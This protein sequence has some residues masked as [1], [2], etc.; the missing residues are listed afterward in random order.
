[1]KRP[2]DEIPIRQK[3]GLSFIVA[4][5]ALKSASSAVHYEVM[6]REFDSPWKDALDEF[7][8]SALEMFH[9]A[10]HADVDWSVPYENLD[11][12]LSAIVREAE[13]GK[14]DADRLYRVTLRNGQ[15]LCLLIHAEVQ[16]QHDA[17]LPRR[18]FVYHYR[19]KD[20]YD[21]PLVGLAI[22]GDESSTWRPNEYNY[23]VY[24]TSNSFRFRSVKLLD[25][26]DRFE[27]LLVNPNPIGVVIAAH[28]RSLETYGQPEE[29]SRAKWQ[30]Y[31]SIFQ[32]GWSAERFRKVYRLIDWLLE[33]PEAVQRQLR[34]EIHQ[35]E[36]EHKMP[37]VP[38]YERFAKEEGRVEGREEGREATL[39]SIELALRAKFGADGKRF[40]E[41]LRSKQ[42]TM[43]MLDRLIDTIDTATSVDELRL[44][45]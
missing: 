29:R 8:E 36:Q 27:E 14:T 10:L 5:S 7:L 18:M 41:E 42:P 19:L 40:G 32:R 3:F 21:E 33:L 13:L 2:A 11:A 31:R 20:R 12:E 28:L 24:E 17:D 38:S 37:F 16:S 43:E 6:T 34:F 23:G 25:W 26:R 44:T 22:L 9:P 45:P 1:V 4:S 39:R 30:L 15:P 35:F